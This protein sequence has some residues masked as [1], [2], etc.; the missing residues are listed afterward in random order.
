VV[1]VGWVDVGGFTSSRTFMIRPPI[2]RAWSWLACLR[3]FAWGACSVMTCE[4]LSVALLFCGIGSVSIVRTVA[5]FCQIGSR[6]L[7]A[8]WAK[9]HARAKRPFV[10]NWTNLRFWQVAKAGAKVGG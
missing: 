1:L 2:A 5:R 7:F 3:V 10:P 4:D 9:R 8:F 6:L